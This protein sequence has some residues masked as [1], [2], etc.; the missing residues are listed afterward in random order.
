[1]IGNVKVRF[2][3]CR[4]EVV[5]HGPVSY[6]DRMDTMDIVCPILLVHK[7]TRVLLDFSNA[8]PNTTLGATRAE[9]IARIEAE[10][11]MAGACLAFV[12]GSESH[13]MP[14][15]HASHVAG[16]VARRF[17]D[18]DSATA[19]LDATAPET[20]GPQCRC[21]PLPARPMA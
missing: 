9:F 1:M 3:A 20:E 2:D 5:F 8:W 19:W 11:A 14:T 18:R 12:H 15:E 6:Q 10:P 4:V 13:T 16:F 7:F 21:E 17:Y